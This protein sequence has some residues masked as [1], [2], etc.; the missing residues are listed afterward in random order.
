MRCCAEMML[1][2]LKVVVVFV[3]MNADDKPGLV[4]GCT[5]RELGYWR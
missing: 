5:G 4:R 3:N 1:R 2:W